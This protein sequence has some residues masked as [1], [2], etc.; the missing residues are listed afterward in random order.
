MT[1]LIPTLQYF[2]RLSHFHRLIPHP[3]FLLESD[4]GLFHELIVGS[5]LRAP[6]LSL[7]RHLPSHQSLL[8]K[9][10]KW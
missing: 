10:I 1:S 9:E 8:M 2:V 4:F 5:Q 6:L 7:Y 3:R